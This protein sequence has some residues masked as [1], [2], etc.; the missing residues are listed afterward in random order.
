MEIHGGNIYDKQINLDYSISINPFGLPEKIRREAIRGVELSEHYPD[1][2]CTRLLDEMERAFSQPRERFVIGNGECELIYAAVFAAKP[3][4]ALILGPTFSEYERAF[5]ASGSDYEYYFAKEEE[6]FIVQ[7][8]VLDIL[9]TGGYDMFVV[10]NPNN[11]TG[12]LVKRRLM[13]PLM[14]LCREKGIRVMLDECFM[15]FVRKESE[16]TY[17]NKLDDYS[18][19][20]VLRTLTKTFAMPGLRVGY[21]MS[22]DIA[23]MERMKCVLP[24]WNVSIPAQYAGVEAMRQREFIAQTKEFVNSERRWM[25]DR[26]KALDYPYYTSKANFILFRAD[27]RLKDFCLASRIL[28]RDAGNIP[29]L[30]EGFYRIGVKKRNHN[31]RLFKVL[32]Q[33]KW[34][35]PKK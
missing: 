16:H 27:G 10:C 35:M 31:E 25:E 17:T 18:N 13:G 6:D 34:A 9:Q 24:P 32:E 8:E 33:A 22:S 21:A 7:E 11:P 15:D 29:G 28:I 23:F 1:I 5:I 12:R 30:S 3:K 4:K 2:E 26:L 14:D 20:L 19:I